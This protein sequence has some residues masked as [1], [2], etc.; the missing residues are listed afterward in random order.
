MN[1]Q[2]D[3][4]QAIRFEN[5]PHKYF[6]MMLNMAE[7]DLDP[8]E[9]RLLGHYIRWAGHG[10]IEKEGIRETAKKTKMSVAKVRAARSGL[11]S[12]GYVSV[13]E[14]T[15][16]DQKESKPTEVTVIDRW[17]E[18]IARYTPVSDL[19]RGVSD[20]THPPVS[21]LTPMKNINTEDSMSAA[22]TAKV[23]PLQKRSSRAANRPP[24]SYDDVSHKDRT[25]II[26]AW[27]KNLL[28]APTN[29][30]KTDT[31]HEWAADIFR[32][33]Y[34]PEQVARF[35]RATMND[36]Y[37]KGKTLTLKKVG[38][39]MPAWLV[40]HPTDEVLKPTVL[41]GLKIITA[42]TDERSA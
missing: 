39:L 13:K 30:Y 1:K 18:N 40:Q 34:T 32:A 19:A 28:A 14:S 41:A 4:L 22:Q 16:D 35:V 42:D 29:A 6:H 38:E 17:Q 31:N 24:K 10:G 20:L 25:L 36:Q 26:E 2:P 21:D 11:A 15:V 37:W 23:I 8:F 33:G 9:Y 3:E 5:S 12:K 27:C 7:D